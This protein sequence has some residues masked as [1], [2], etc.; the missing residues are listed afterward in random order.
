MRIFE[1]VGEVRFRL[2]LTSL[3][4]FGVDQAGRVK[5]VGSILRNYS[6][7]SHRSGRIGRIMLATLCLPRVFQGRHANT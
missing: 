2:V 3:V 7:T 6:R 4:K 1:G 5:T